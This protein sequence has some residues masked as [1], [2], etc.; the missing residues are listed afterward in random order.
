[1]KPTFPLPF[2]GAAAL[3]LAVLP[4]AG[5]SDSHHHRRPAFDIGLAQGGVSAASFTTL[6]D[7]ISHPTV[8]L[9]LQNMP[10]HVGAA[11][12]DVSG[13]YDFLG[14]VI[15]TSYPGSLTGDQVSAI[16]CF[17]KPYGKLLDVAVADTQALD[18]GATYFIEGSD[19]RFTVY[20]A[21][22]LLDASGGGTCEFHVVNVYSGR[23]RADGSLVD[24]YVGQGIVGLVGDCGPFLIGDVEVSWGD[25]I[26]L[27][28]TGEPVP[29]GG[30]LDPDKV[31]VVVNNSL[32]NPVDVFVNLETDATPL[33]VTIPAADEVAFEVAPC[34]DLTTASVQPLGGQDAQGNDVLMGEAVV[35]FFPPDCT[36]PG[37]TV[38]YYVTNE[39][40]GDIFFAPRPVNQSAGDIYSVVNAG[41]EIPEY[42][43][44]GDLGFDCF[45]ALPPDPLEY[46]IGYYSYSRPGIISENEANVDFYRVADDSPIGPGPAFGPFLLELG[47]GAKQFLVTEDGIFP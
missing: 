23:Q 34:F 21:F 13:S 1:M 7:Y 4:G 29:G 10:R 16:F 26:L 14:E 35:A 36:S 39:V 15:A 25:A 2:L 19:D 30:P 3:A 46:D 47:S 20:L 41:V 27:A 38:T 6:S 5:C 32:L 22:V 31:Q 24:M 42:P 40:G 11:P 12:R 43:E 44:V 17:G 28:E 18:A 9:I 45:C 33:T 8:Q 37:A